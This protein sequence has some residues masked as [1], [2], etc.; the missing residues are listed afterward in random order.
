MKSKKRT[1]NKKKGSYNKISNN[2]ILNSSRSKSMSNITIKTNYTFI[3]KSTE[4]KLT[5]N[6]LKKK[7]NFFFKKDF[8]THIKENETSFINCIRYYNKEEKKII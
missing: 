2:Q 5:K 3:N 1:H 8:D 4:K 7:F 6:K